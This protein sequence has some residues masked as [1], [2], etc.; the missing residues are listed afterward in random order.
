MLQ[1]MIKNKRNENYE[2]GVDVATRLL[3]PLALLADD[4]AV[5]GSIKVGWILGISRVFV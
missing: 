4:H 5:A 2:V 1:M 3:F